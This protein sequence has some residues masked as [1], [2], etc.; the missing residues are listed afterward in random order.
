MMPESLTAAITQIF[1]VFSDAA[2]QFGSGVLLFIPAMFIANW[3]WNKVIRAIKR[4]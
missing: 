4:R 1:S 3:G 2:G